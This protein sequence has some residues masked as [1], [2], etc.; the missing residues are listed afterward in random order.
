VVV[1]YPKLILI[2]PW[3]FV[4]FSN[5]QRKQVFPPLPRRKVLKLDHKKRKT[6]N[7]RQKNQGDH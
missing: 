1:V 3:V 4:F 5:K 6:N 7:H 2:T